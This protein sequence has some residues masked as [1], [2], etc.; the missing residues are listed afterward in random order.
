[1]KVRIALPSEILHDLMRRSCMDAQGYLLVTAIC[2]W[3]RA[4]QTRNEIRETLYKTLR[5]RRGDS[6]TIPGICRN[7]GDVAKRQPRRM[8]VTQQSRPVRRWCFAGKKACLQNV[9]KQAFKRSKQPVTRDP[10]CNG[11]VSFPPPMASALSCWRDEDWP[12]ESNE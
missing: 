2:F 8:N 7:R 12:R 4:N 3:P 5:R 6:E 9:L 10:Y 1:M 11:R